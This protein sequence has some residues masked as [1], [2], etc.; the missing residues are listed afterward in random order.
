MPRPCW[1][2]GITDEN[3]QKLGGLVGMFGEFREHTLKDGIRGVIRSSEVPL[4][5][6]ESAFW[7]FGVLVLRTANA[8]RWYESVNR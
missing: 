4:D 7:R 8:Q 2:R 3:A 5:S 1:R 6:I